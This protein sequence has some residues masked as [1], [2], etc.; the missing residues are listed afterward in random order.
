MTPTIKPRPASKMMV[1]KK[2]TNQTACKRN[3]EA[4]TVLK[5]KTQFLLYVHVYAH[6][7]TMLSDNEWKGN[8]IWFIEATISFLEM[9]EMTKHILGLK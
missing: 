1:A 9:C 5:T 3:K 7:I 6:V 4:V 8:E 2:V